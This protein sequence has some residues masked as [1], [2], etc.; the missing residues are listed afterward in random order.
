M[1]KEK[2]SEIDFSR[3]SFQN[4]IELLKGSRFEEEDHKSLLAPMLLDHDE[5]DS[6]YQNAL[7]ILD[8][9]SSRP[10]T[11]ASLVPSPGRVHMYDPNSNQSERKSLPAF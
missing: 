6:Q 11:R 3:I 2:Y 9:I 1:E 4:E 7:M 8:D 5:I 10:F